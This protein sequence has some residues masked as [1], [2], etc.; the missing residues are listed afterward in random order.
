VPLSG[1]IAARGWFNDSIEHTGWSTLTIETSPYHS[2]LDQIYAAGYVEGVL[3]HERITSHII[4]LADATY[5]DFPE[6]APAALLQWYTRQLEW[7][8][9]MINSHTTDTDSFWQS[10]QLWLHQLEGIAHGYNEA[11]PKIATVLTIEYLMLMQDAGGHGTPALAR[12][13]ITA[14]MCRAYLPLSLH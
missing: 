10:M 7:T 4:N 2:P 12:C 14:C 13:C 11:K 5:H 8:R 1:R 9:S 3:T 6:G